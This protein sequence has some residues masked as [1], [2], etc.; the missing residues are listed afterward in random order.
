MQDSRDLTVVVPRRNISGRALRY[1]PFSSKC[2]IKGKTYLP[3]CVITIKL[4]SVAVIRKQTIL[5]E[6]PP[7]VSEV[8]ANL[9]G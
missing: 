2:F 9:C 5:T 7:L 1:G 3:K 4:N 6:Q 8:S